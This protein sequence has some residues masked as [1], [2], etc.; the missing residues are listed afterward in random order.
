MTITNSIFCDECDSLD[1]LSMVEDGELTLSTEDELL[2]LD[3]G[4]NKHNII[5][6]TT[7]DA[8]PDSILEAGSLF[9][10]NQ[11]RNIYYGNGTEN[12]RVGIFYKR[13][14]I[15]V[16]SRSVKTTPTSPTEGDQY[17]IP[18]SG[19]WSGLVN[20]IARF[21][22]GR[23]LFVVPSEGQRCGVRDESIDY[24]FNGYAWEKDVQ[25]NWVEAIS[26]SST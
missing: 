8:D 2:F 14:G 18:N 4:I 11:N 23:W 3:H 20:Q 25:S 1:I 19:N 7:S 16:I 12:I 10:N 24:I 5:N 15:N 21:S 13:D 17:I 9:F 6:V 26:S 22:D